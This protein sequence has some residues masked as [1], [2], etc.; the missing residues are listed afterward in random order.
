[1]SETAP[2]ET[3][4]G[5]EHIKAPIRTPAGASHLFNLRLDELVAEVVSDAVRYFVD[6]NELAAGDYG[7]A[8]I[9]DGQAEPMVDTSRLKD[10]GITDADVLQ[11]IPEAPQV[12]G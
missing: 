1:M 8:V 3:A 2:H 12:D 5:H 11:L 9:R 4:Q 10:Y 6:H 7:L